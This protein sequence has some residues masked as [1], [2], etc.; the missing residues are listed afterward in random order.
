MLS[1]RNRLPEE[2]KVIRASKT[3]CATLGGMFGGLFLVS[4][5]FGLCVHPTFW[6]AAGIFVL[7]LI[8]S[9]VWLYNHKVVLSKKGITYRTPFAGTVTIEWNNIRT[10]E[11]KIGY[12]LAES[13]GSFRPPF[14]LVLTPKIPSQRCIIINVKMLSRAD[15]SELIQV[16]ELEAEQCTFPAKSV[17]S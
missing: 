5:I 15:L 8:I 10:A 17:W 1:T 4:F 11:I 9:V 3:A 7:P 13:G 6:A 2:E 16:L 14:R 12:F